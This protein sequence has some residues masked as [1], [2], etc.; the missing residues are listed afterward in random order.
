MM[1]AQ[2]LRERLFV[3]TSIDSYG[4]KPHP[5]RILNAEMAQPADT[6][7]CDYVSGAS[8]RVTQRVVNRDTGAHE[9]SGFLSRNFIGDRGERSRRG[10]HV[11]S[12]SSIEVNA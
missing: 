11:F 5:S 10:N 1:R 12:V 9:W 4:L 8:T 2:L 6:M 3:V 7:N